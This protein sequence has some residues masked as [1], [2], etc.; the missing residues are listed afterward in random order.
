[1]EEWKVIENHNNYEI[2]NLG[3]VRNIKTGRIL[4]YYIAGGGYYYTR[5]GAGKK[6]LVHRLVGKSFIENDDENKKEI[7]HIDRNKLNNNMNNLRWVNKHQNMMNVESKWICEVT[8]Y[9][10]YRVS[11]SIGYKNQIQKTFKYKEDAEE[12]LNELKI[13]YPRFI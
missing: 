9:K 7:D 10:Y 13:N 11:Y 1:M 4:K 2:S 3:N 6:Y 5:L 8:K 12:Y